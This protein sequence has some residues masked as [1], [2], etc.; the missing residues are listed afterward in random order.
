MPKSNT[1]RNKQDMRVRIGAD[2]VC[3][4]VACGIL[5]LEAVPCDGS[6]QRIRTKG[7]LGRI[8]G[9]LEG[10]FVLP[11]RFS[12]CEAWEKALPEGAE[13]MDRTE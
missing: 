9:V 4:V 12:V 13:E 1:V 10:A 6:G 8:K 7:E 11:V 2:G 5:T 3:T